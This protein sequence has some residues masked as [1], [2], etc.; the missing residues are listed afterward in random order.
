MRFKN[1]TSGGIN[2]CLPTKERQT[3]IPHAIAL[4]A[5]CSSRFHLNCNILNDVLDNQPTT[6]IT[7]KASLD[8][9][10]AH[11]KSLNIDFCFDFFLP[12]F[13]FVPVLFI[14]S[15]FVIQACLHLLFLLHS[16]FSSF[17]SFPSNFSSL[18]LPNS[19]FSISPPFFLLEKHIAYE[20]A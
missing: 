17:L 1:I 19:T 12:L 2:V 10:A 4:S 13:L 18:F 11:E 3:R 7:P 8:H 15:L 16:F 6:G 14:F 9:N 5:L 20:G